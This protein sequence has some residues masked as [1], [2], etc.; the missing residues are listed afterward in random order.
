MTKCDVDISSVENLSDSLKRW[1]SVPLSFTSQELIEE[2]EAIQDNA[3]SVIREARGKIALIEA[4]N[5]ALTASLLAAQAADLASAAAGEPANAVQEIEFKI[6]AN[7]ARIGKIHLAINDIQDNVIDRIESAMEAYV[8]KAKRLERE[9]NDRFIEVVDVLDDYIRD[10]DAGKSELSGEHLHNSS[11]DA[12]FDNHGDRNTI[13]LED[14]IGVIAYSGDGLLG[15]MALSGGNYAS[16]I[17]EE[18]KAKEIDALKEAELGT[19]LGHRHPKHFGEWTDSQ[20]NVVSP[21]TCIDKGIYFWTPESTHV[22]GGKQNNPLGL[23]A[24]EVAQKYGFHSFTYKDGY[25]VFPES[26]I[27]ASVSLEGVLS[28]ER[29]KNFEEAAVLLIKTNGQG[30]RPEFCRMV[31]DFMLV[32]PNSG[33]WFNSKTQVEKFRK[34]HRL[35]WH[36]SEDMRD[37]QL[38]PRELHSMALHD[39]GVSNA[40]Y[41]ERLELEFRLLAKAALDD[42]LSGN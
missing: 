14:D 1:A 28:S 11:R 32:Y 9:Y 5:A 3:K 35:T 15:E 6:A 34:L 26:S 39:G 36:E 42:M 18:T 29:P 10:M 33:N 22:F 21:S 24:G 27:M 38:I 12:N 17:A 4:E 40:R 2:K 25:P 30:Q 19:S 31:S 16:M 41:R 13:T 8:D 20:G 7:K 23:T 37:I